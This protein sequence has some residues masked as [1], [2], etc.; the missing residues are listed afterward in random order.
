MTQ[1]PAR[2]KPRLFDVVLLAVAVAGL[3]LCIT[4]LYQGMR[5]VLDV[6]GACADG[7]PYVS[8]QPCPDGSP[9]ALFLG[10]FGLFGFGALGMVYGA[11]VGGYGWVPLLAW[12]G[13][14]ASLG[15]NFLD[16]GLFNPPTGEIEWGYLIPGVMFQLMAWVP[17]A[18]L[19]MG[20]W[21]ARGTPSSGPRPN[22]IM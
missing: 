11:K 12:T 5:A 6:G 18:F 16:Y 2:A 13:L 8:A 22:R 17:V 19:A 20:L 3:T 15:W 21:E 1:A 4:L 7:G 14:F 10:A 9:A